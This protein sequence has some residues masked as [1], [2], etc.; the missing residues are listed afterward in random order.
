M[1]ILI[2]MPVN[3]LHRQSLVYVMF[4]NIG[5]APDL[6]LD[7][8]ERDGPA[9]RKRRTGDDLDADSETDGDPS[10]GPS[11]SPLSK[12]AVKLLATPDESI[13]R[14]EHKKTKV[15]QAK[16]VHAH[17]FR[18][19]MLYAL[20]NQATDK[21]QQQLVFCVKTFTASMLKGDK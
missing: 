13:S 6:D 17:G 12:R 5:D 10:T 14:V 11:P 15:E 2:S 3:W 21:D 16:G 20:Q 1:A 4:G 18:E 9:N 19:N 7:L 8:A